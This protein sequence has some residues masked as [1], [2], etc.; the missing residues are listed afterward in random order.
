[1][2]FDGDDAIIAHVH[3]SAYAILFARSPDMLALLARFAAGECDFE[4]GQHASDCRAC[5]AQVLIAQIEQETQD[6]LPH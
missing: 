6:T 5:C 1:M 4:D 2:L 3:Q